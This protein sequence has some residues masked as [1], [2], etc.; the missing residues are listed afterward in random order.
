MPM[1]VMYAIVGQSF[2]IYCSQGS[3]FA[4]HHL[5]FPSPPLLDDFIPLVM[6][7]VLAGDCAWLVLPSTTNEEKEEE[8]P[9]LLPPYNLSQFVRQTEK[10]TD[11][12]ISPSAFYTLPCL[13]LANTR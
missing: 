8:E 5:F 3:A 1:Y 6:P 2:P 11:R 12:Q 4:Q 10:N 9:V 7:V 13:V